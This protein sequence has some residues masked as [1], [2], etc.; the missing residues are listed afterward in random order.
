MHALNNRELG[1]YPTIQYRFLDNAARKRTVRFVMYLSK[2]SN[3]RD[4]YAFDVAGA[5]GGYVA[6]PG[7]PGQSPVFSNLTMLETQCGATGIIVG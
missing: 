6:E 4:L 2:D 7:T 5:V 1:T 3:G